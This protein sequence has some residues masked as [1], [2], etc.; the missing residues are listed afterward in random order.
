M[1]RAFVSTGA[2]KRMLADMVWCR[3]FKRE[4]AP[5]KRKRAAPQDTSGAKVPRMQ[6]ALNS[7]SV[8]VLKSE[9]ASGDEAGDSGSGGDSDAEVVL[10]HHTIV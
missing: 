10:S 9:R 8:S 1:L 2:L 4:R 5:R 7:S 6:N 3:S